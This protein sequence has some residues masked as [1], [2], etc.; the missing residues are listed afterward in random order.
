MRHHAC[1]PGP[2]QSTFRAGF[3]KVLLA[4][5]RAPCTIREVFQEGKSMKNRASLAALALLATAC[6][7]MPGGEYAKPYALI[8]NET[9]YIGQDIRPAWVVSIDGKD[10]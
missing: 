4:G 6:A 8:Q 5:R 1:E 10:I 3:T 2:P 9:R 7:S